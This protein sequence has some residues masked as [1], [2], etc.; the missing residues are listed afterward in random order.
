M[1]LKLETVVLGDEASL[2][3][4]LIPIE[5]DNVGLGAGIARCLKDKDVLALKQMRYGCLDEIPLLAV[6]GGVGDEVIVDTDTDV[7]IWL[8]GVGGSAQQR[9]SENALTIGQ[10]R[11]GISKRDRGGS[12][13]RLPVPTVSFL[14]GFGPVQEILLAMEGSPEGGGKCDGIS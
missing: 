14:W 8:D 10:V 11:Q 3:A 7:V 2:I 9:D 4:D 12:D 13:E 6:P 1:S 5:Q